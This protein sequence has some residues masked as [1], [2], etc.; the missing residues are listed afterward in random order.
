MINKKIFESKRFNEAFDTDY[1][2]LSTSLKLNEIGHF[3][4][5]KIILTLRIQVAVIKSLILKKYDFYYITL[6]TKSIG[7]LKDIFLIIILKIFNKRLIYHINNRGVKEF[8][9]K[10]FYHILYRIAFSN[11]DV[12]LTSPMLYVDVE[13]Y[14]PNSNVYFCPNGIEKIVIKGSVSHNNIV[15]I[16]FLSNLMREKGVF[17][18]L[19]AC[20]LL[21]K[22]GHIFECRFIGGLT[23]I[24]NEELKECIEEFGLMDC[25]KYLGPKYEEEKYK[26]LANA[27]IFV[28]P[29]YYMVECF[30][31]SII[32]AMQ[33]AIPIV[34]TKHAAIPEM[35]DDGVNGFLVT[36]RDPNELADRLKILIENPELRNL[37]GANAEKKYLENYTFE[38]FETK[39]L[40]II[41][42]I[43]RKRTVK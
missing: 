6:T 10:K 8:E 11:V 25:V 17:E 2:N 12:I 40:S 36:P 13:K 9:S 39:L 1:F 30:P 42:A 32:E 33:F 22:N 4:I 14:V 24:T 26:E 20:E 35:V 43:Y 34:S 31:L 27:S 3:G 16:V 29:T 41:N 5:H 7:F 28:L 21:K 37:M 19:K 18:L 38:K 15:R 23:D